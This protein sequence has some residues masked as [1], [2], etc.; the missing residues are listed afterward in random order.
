MAGGES[1]VDR[2]QQAFTSV[3]DDV[4]LCDFFSQSRTVPVANDRLTIIF[5]GKRVF[6]VDMNRVKVGA[7]PTNRNYLAACL[8]SG[9]KYVG[10]VKG[11][12]VAPVP[13]VEADFVAQ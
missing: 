6:A 5:D 13:T 9:V 8:A 1:G 2:C 4:G 11:S 3:L 7:L 10:V 12:A